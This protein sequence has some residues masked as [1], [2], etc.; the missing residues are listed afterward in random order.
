M[1]MPDINTKRILMLQ[2][3]IIIGREVKRIKV[4]F[5]ITQRIIFI[6]RILSCIVILSIASFGSK[7]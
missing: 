3:Y 1:V 5:Y 6:F 4:F 2:F 7:L